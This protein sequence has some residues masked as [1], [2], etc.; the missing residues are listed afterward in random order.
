MPYGNQIYR[1][2]RTKFKIYWH[3]Y[4]D[5]D[6]MESKHLHGKETHKGPI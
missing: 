6:W 4:A 5:H 1:L 3:L 2:L